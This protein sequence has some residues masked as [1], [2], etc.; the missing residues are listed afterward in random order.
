MHQEERGVRSPFQPQAALRPVTIGISRP[1]SVGH[2]LPSVGPSLVRQRE[3]GQLFPRRRDDEDPQPVQL[4]VVWVVAVEALESGPV[5]DNPTL[6][7]ALVEALVAAASVVVALRE[8]RPQLKFDRRSLL[9]LMLEL[10][11]CGHRAADRARR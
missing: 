6:I 4:A 3:N 1:V 8:V 5:A 11:R 7:R 10:I 2:F 9:D